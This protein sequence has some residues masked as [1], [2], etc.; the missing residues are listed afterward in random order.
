MKTKVELQRKDH[1]SR[2]SAEGDSRKKTEKCVNGGGDKAITMT[3]CGVCC[4]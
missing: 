1:A 2:K 3:T 4:G